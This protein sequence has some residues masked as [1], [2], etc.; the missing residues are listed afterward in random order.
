MVPFGSDAPPSESEM[1]SAL[2]Q[3]IAEQARRLVASIQDACQSIW[4]THRGRPVQEIAPA[5]RA[6]FAQRWI[7]PNLADGFAGYIAAGKR[8]ALRPR[9]EAR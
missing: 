4:E 3:A 9:V 2:R 5:L 7:D 8:V 1:E 6:A